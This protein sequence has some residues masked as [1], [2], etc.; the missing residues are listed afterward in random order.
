MAVGYQFDQ[1][2]ANQQLG[3]LA[4]QLRD[5]MVAV[6]SYHQKVTGLGHAGQMALGFTDADATDLQL[7]ADYIY[8]IAAVYYGTA[9]QTPPFNFDDALS[10]PRAGR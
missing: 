5:L 8:T 1:D 7:R 3:S 9:G 2:R 6:T 10:G 4:V